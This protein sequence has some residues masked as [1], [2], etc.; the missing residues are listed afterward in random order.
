M[1]FRSKPKVG[2]VKEPKV[3][4]DVQLEKAVDYLRDQVKAV[5]EK[6]AKK[7]G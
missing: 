3:F 6:P 2:P 7:A 1:L 5:A 4:K